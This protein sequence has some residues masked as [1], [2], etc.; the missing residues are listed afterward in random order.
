MLWDIF[1]CKELCPCC[2]VVYDC[3]LSTCMVGM[4]TFSNPDFFYLENHNHTILSTISYRPT[5]N[6]VLKRQY[7]CYIRSRI[8]P[9]GLEGLMKWW[10]FLYRWKV[11]TIDTQY[12]G[13][14]P[15]P[16]SSEL[17]LRPPWFEFRIL[18][19][20]GR[21]I[22]FILSSSPGLIDK[23]KKT[24]ISFNFIYFFF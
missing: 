9:E 20:E 4:A 5:R 18:C 11:S 17:S 23:T 22:S 2:V 13:E 6:W 14:P 19:L 24:F 1:F 8:Q 10:V 15:W 12:C 16:R 7:K 21:V 3:V